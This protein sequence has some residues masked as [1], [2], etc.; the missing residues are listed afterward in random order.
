MVVT[1][2]SLRSLAGNTDNLTEALSGSDAAVC[3]SAERRPTASPQR[4]IKVEIENVE[5]PCL[6]LSPG[7]YYTTK[8]HYYAQRLRRSDVSRCAV[9]CKRLCCVGSVDVRVCM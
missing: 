7:F 4:A 3:R 5:V 2:A 9:V 8:S 1:E 6:L